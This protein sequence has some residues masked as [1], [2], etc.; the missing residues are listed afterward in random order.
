MAR[1]FASGSWDGTVALWDS[2]SGLQFRSIHAATEYIPLFKTRVFGKWGVLAIAWSPDGTT[3]ATSS[4]DKSIELWDPASGLLIRTLN[5]EIRDKVRLHSWRPSSA[6][7]LS[8][9]PDG[10]ILS[11]TSDGKEITLWD[12]SSGA[13]LR[14]LHGDDIYVLHCFQKKSQVTSKQDRAI[15]AAR[16]RAAVNVRKEK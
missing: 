1:F 5:P 3:L 7:C 14:S 8:W 2:T 4:V 15:A 9:S 16:Y 13:T 6:A 12:P 11:S 10:R